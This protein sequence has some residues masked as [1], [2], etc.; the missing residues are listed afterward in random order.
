MVSFLM[1]ETNCTVGLVTPSPFYE[2]LGVGGQT[3]KRYYK[4]LAVGG[5]TPKRYYKLFGVGLPMV[6]ERHPPHRASCP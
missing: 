2:L 4:L 6:L 3:P 5:Q 1:S